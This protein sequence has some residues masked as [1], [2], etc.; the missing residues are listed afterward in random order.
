MV[1]K[2]KDKPPKPPKRDLGKDTLA[3][4]LDG[5]MFVN[6][7]CYRADELAV[8]MDL[9]KEMNFTITAFH[10]TTEAYKVAD[11]LAD[12]DI[13]AVMWSDW[14]GYKAEA[15]DAIPE[16]IALVDKAGACAI[17]HSDSEG[18]IQHMNLEV[19]KAMAAGN[20]A[21]M[22]IT[23]EHAFTWITSN[24][25]RAM[26]IDEKVGSLEVGKDADLVIW[27]G[28]PFSIYSLAEDVFIDGAHVYDR[29]DPAR[30][31]QSDYELGIVKRGDF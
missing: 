3:A 25:A 18:V 1:M 8:M 7:H 31:P 27:S 22:E 5:H 15:L 2:I 9:A 10:H 30:N 29:D 6:I 4:V 14:W 17:A 16:N 23:R 20:R 21:G 13:C 12:N 24:P 28:D 26:R 11:M 19:A